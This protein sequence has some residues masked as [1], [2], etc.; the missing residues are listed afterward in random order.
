MKTGHVVFLYPF[1]SEWLVVSS[2]VNNK[3]RESFSPGNR[4]LKT[5]NIEIEKY[6]RQQRIWHQ[7]KTIIKGY[8]Q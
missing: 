6:T 8:S 1:Q 2:R 7:K 3:M 4:F 5:K